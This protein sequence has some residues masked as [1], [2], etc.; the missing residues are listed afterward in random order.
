MIGTGVVSWITARILSRHRG[1][2]ETVN[3]EST[4]L[5][6]VINGAPLYAESGNA[7]SPG[8]TPCSGRIGSLPTFQLGLVERGGA[9]RRGGYHSLLKSTADVTKNKIIGDGIVKQN[10]KQA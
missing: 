8:N 10:E 4:S 9:V 7:D 1:Q 6:D 2:Q 5:E 3:V